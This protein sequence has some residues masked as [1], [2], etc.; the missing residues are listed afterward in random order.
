MK[1][2]GMGEAAVREPEFLIESLDVGDQRVFVPFRDS[3]AEI[4]RIV[5][6]AANLALLRPPVG[7]DDP[8]GAISAAHELENAFA[9]PVFDELHPVRALELTRAA[10]R[11]TKQIARVVPQQVALT[12]FI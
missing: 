9:V 3:P 10:R 7:V 8:V 5:S 12:Q 2:F 11:D 6:I 1:L 4:Q